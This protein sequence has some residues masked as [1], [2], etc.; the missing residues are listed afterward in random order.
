MAQ[1]SIND[2]ARMTGYAKSSVSAALNNKPGVSDATRK[3][4]LDLCKKLNYTPNEIAKS[5]SIGSYKTIGII[6]RDISNPFYAKLCRAVE[7]ICEDNGYTTLIF[8]TDGSEA[9]LSNAINQLI[10]RRVDGVIVDVSSHNENY[11]HCLDDQQIKTVIFGLQ[12]DNYDSV[13]CDDITGGYDLANKIYEKG[14]RNIAFFC[15]KFERNIYAKRRHVGISNLKNKYGD[16]NLEV[17][18]YEGSSSVESGFMLMKNYLSNNQKLPDAIMAFN[19]VVAVGI[20]RCLQEHKISVPDDVM[21]TGFDNLETIL[22]PLDTVDIPVFD[23]GISAS[24]LL[25]ERIKNPH[26]EKEHIVL[27][28][29]IISRK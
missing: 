13:S 26:K 14:A 22:F 12:S 9:R 19:D 25:F 7:K 29:K 20:I 23:M 4:I 15:P 16:C 8:N 17:V 6:V 5:I 1:Y 24:K 10:G 21:V 2:I 3:K 11:L 28:A 18:T 27:D